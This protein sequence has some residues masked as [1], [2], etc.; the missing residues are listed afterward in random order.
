MKKI[1]FLALILASFQ[2]V[3][4]DFSDVEYTGELIENEMSFKAFCEGINNADARCANSDEYVLAG[5]LLE[6]NQ[7]S[8][9]IVKNAEFAAIEGKKVRAKFNYPNP[10][11]TVVE[12]F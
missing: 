5:V 12:V 2:A 7:A 9:V 10:I 8:S 4:G 1:T 11:G 3:S 6:E